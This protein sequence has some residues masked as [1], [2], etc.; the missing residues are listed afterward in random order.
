[1]AKTFL[2]TVRINGYNVELR[3]F[4]LLGTGVVCDRNGATHDSGVT[5]LSEAETGGTVQPYFFSY[6]FIYKL[7]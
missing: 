3:T 4:E 7:L 6:F 2:Y 5:F 1:L